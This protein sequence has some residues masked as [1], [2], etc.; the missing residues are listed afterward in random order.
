MRNES[1]LKKDLF[2]QPIEAGET[3]PETFNMKPLF[4]LNLQEFIEPDNWDEIGGKEQQQALRLRAM[5]KHFLQMADLLD[6]LGNYLKCLP[7]EYDFTPSEFEQTWEELNEEA[8]KE[9]SATYSKLQTVVDEL[10]ESS[11]DNFM[12]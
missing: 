4:L 8:E 5:A 7:D 9:I 12:S 3:V 2:L 1:G 10:E 11:T 6:G